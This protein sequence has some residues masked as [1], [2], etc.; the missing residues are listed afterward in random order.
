MFYVNESEHDTLDNANITCKM[1]TND[2]GRVVRVDSYDEQFFLNWGL[3]DRDV[4]RGNRIFVGH[5]Y[6]STTSTM[7]YYGSS[8]NG[9][10]SAEWPDGDWWA[11]TYPRNKANKECVALVY[12]YTSEEWLFGDVSCDEE[13]GFICE[14]P[15]TPGGVSE[16]GPWSQCTDS[17]GSGTQIRYREC[18]NPVPVLDGQFCQDSLNDTRSCEDRCSVVTCPDGWLTG[19]DSCYKQVLGSLADYSS[20]N[21]SCNM[22]TNDTGHLLYINNQT[23]LDEVSWLFI[24]RGESESIEYLTGLLYESSTLSFDDGIGAPDATSWRTEEG[25]PWVKN[26]PAGS[27]TCVGLAYNGKTWEWR[28]INVD[29]TDSMYYI[30]EITQTDGNW[31]SWGEWSACSQTCDES[32]DMGTRHRNRTCS[33]P[34]PILDGNYCEGNKTEYGACGSQCPAVHGNYSDWINGECSVSCYS[35]DS[36]GNRYGGFLN[37]TRNC[38]NPAP[39][40]GG[41]NCTDLG[42]E[43]E[44]VS[45]GTEDGNACPA[46]NGSWGNWSNWTSCNVTCGSGYKVRTR[47]CD[48]PSPEH[49]GADCEGDDTDLLSCTRL[50]CPIDGNWTDWS[51]W[52]VCSQTCVGGTQYRTRACSDPTPMYNGT[53][54]SGDDIQ[55]QNCSSDVTCPIHGGWSEWSSWSA[56]SL[57]CGGVGTTTRNRSC[58]NPSPAHGGNSCP[59][60]DDS[61]ESEACGNANCPIDGDYSSWGSWS[62]C[63]INCGEGGVRYRYRACD[64]PEPQYGGL[65]CDL[66]DLYLRQSCDSTVNCTAER[67]DFYQNKPTSQSS[68]A[69]G[70]DSY[71]AVDNDFNS[72]FSSGSCMETDVELNPWWQVD[73]GGVYQVRSV[74]IYVRSDDCLDCTWTLTPLVVRLGVSSTPKENMRC[75][76]IVESYS[77]SVVDVSCDLMAGRYLSIQNVDDMETSLSFCEV[78][79]NIGSYA[80]FDGSANVTFSNA[81]AECYQRGAELATPDDLLD[82]YDNGDESCDWGWASDGS[83]RRVVQ[84]SSECAANGSSGGVVDKGASAQSGEWGVYCI[85]RSEGKNLIGLLISDVSFNASSSQPGL[86]PT[87]ANVYNENDTLGWV[88]QNSTDGEWLE[89]DFGQYIALTGVATR[90][91][92]CCDGHVTG[93]YLKYSSDG[94][95]WS[96]YGSGATKLIQGNMDSTSVV[97]A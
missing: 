79:V 69:S 36:D 83:V 97:G 37:R 43:F 13:N 67:E 51:S 8:G 4:G 76:N 16:W 15:Q 58:N 31:G 56:C 23:E 93:Y 42:D 19:Y 14:I 55:W 95:N 49:G 84:S 63:S 29:C 1:L 61:E 54:C 50:P 7:L 48:S 46:I 18:D 35:W 41:D 52:S 72:N 65:D 74:S 68:T 87:K 77:S 9:P 85:Q 73:L 45:C 39:L 82:M 90:G 25:A 17:C 2:T 47:S 70:G 27:G 86:D 38:T 59:A 80:F 6:D 91:R 96:Y 28:L 26:Y 78:V 11:S 81:Q 89:I 12:D 92:P 21:Q 53:E 32:A 44:T 94:E 33:D 5:T 10:S 88:P 75:G 34:A 24:K 20:A 57:S 64:N 40:Y 22:L 66:N 3:K 30:C 71:R 62:D 60:A